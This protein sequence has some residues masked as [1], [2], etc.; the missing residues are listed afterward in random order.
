MTNPGPGC[1]VVFR[2]NLSTRQEAV[3]YSFSGGADGAQ[4]WSGLSRDS[5]GNLFG[6]TAFGGIHNAGVIFQL[7]R[8]GRETVLFAFNNQDGSVPTGDLS[9][10][11]SG[12]F[13][14]TTVTGG[15]PGRCDGLGCGVV[16]SVSASG[17]M[18]HFFTG[19][20]TGDGANATHGVIRDEAGNV[21][22]TTENGGLPAF[23]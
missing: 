6:T 16:F 1:G 10:D 3:L 8:L 17:A 20:S 22:G 23:S 18:S 9:G 15:N 13:F 4:P 5:T 12:N 11:Q 19:P 14:G 21:Y 2:L 7:D